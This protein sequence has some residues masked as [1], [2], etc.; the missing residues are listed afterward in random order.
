M[1]FSF[2]FNE[3]SYFT[4]PYFESHHD[5]S[6]HITIITIIIILHIS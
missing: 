3:H 2:F 1:F 6:L 4:V 5:P